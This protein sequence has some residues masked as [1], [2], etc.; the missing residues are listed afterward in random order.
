MRQDDDPP[1]PNAP[2]PV[3]FWVLIAIIAVAAFVV[4]MGALGPVA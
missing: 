4:V 3:I 2:M 1:R